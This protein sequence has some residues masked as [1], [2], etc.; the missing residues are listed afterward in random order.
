V[1]KR[2]HWTSDPRDGGQTFI[3]TDR[4]FCYNWWIALFGIFNTLHCRQRSTRNIDGLPWFLWLT[5]VDPVEAAQRRV[6]FRRIDSMIHES[7]L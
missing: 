1:T 4:L 5:K 7:E 2:G 6:S 3:S